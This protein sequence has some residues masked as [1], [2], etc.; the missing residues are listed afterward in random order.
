MRNRIVGIMV[1]GIALII[2]FIIY[3]FNQAMASIVNTSCSHGPSC[4]M[5]GTINFQTNMSAVIMA[6]VLLVGLYLVF[7]GQE[8]KII[9]RIRKV[10]LQAAPKKIT[11]D[12][13]RD[14]L[15]TLGSDERAVLSKVIDS[16][17]TELQSALVSDSLSKVRVT[18]AID[19]LE[20]RGIVERKRRGMTNVV[21]LKP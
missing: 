12:G 19:K 17:G 7:F 13:Y 9:T 14:I 2:G 18:R 6:I 16:N 8:E 5:W 3:S 1:I 20:G 10:S 15:K 4:P 11:R 21:V